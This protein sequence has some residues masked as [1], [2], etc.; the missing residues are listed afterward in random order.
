MDIDSV[1]SYAYEIR[2]PTGNGQVTIGSRLDDE[3]TVKVNGT[4]LAKLENIPIQGFRK[5]IE[6]EVVF[7]LIDLFAQ[8]A[9]QGFEARLI[10]LAFEHRLLNPLAIVF[11]YLRDT[12]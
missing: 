11:A 2:G 8:L 12:S 6:A 9:L 10:N 4:K 7:L 3:R 1:Y 5:T